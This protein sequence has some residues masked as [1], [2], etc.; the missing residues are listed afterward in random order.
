M[1]AQGSDVT[2]VRAPHLGCQALEPPALEYSCLHLSAWCPL[3]QMERRCVRGRRSKSVVRIPHTLAR[4]FQW[5]RVTGYFFICSLGLMA[6]SP[7]PLLVKCAQISG[8][9]TQ[10]GSLKTVE[11]VHVSFKKES[12]PGPSFCDRPYF[13]ATCCPRSPPI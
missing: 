7:Q 9:P 10:L 3:R 4:C 1:T 5:L 8:L 12:V 13:S 6:G 11:W 2:P